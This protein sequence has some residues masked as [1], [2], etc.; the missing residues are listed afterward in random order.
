[1]SSTP[2]SATASRTASQTS[3]LAERSADVSHK[4]GAFGGEYYA[5][6]PPFEQRY[7]KPILQKSDLLPDGPVCY[8][9]IGGRSHK[10]TVPSRCLESAHGVERWKTSFFHR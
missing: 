2:A 9:Q 4:V 6:R 10:A 1:M 5:A 3:E 8:M 7:S